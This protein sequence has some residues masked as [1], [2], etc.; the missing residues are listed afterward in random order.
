[1]VPTS[2]G[3]TCTPC[4]PNHLTTSSTF[5]LGPVNSSAITKPSLSAEADRTLNSR[6][7]FLTIWYSKGF[8]PV[9][10]SNVSQYRKLSFLPAMGINR[11]QSRARCSL[12]PPP[13]T[14]SAGSAKTGCP[15][16]PHKCS[17]TDVPPPSHPPTARES[18]GTPSPAPPASPGCPSLPPPRCLSA[19]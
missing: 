13:S 17:R 8:F 18:R 5:S 6:S 1:M 3:S 15:H 10:G 4:F 14:G 12:H 11:P 2:T 7:N 16:P 9:S 19:R